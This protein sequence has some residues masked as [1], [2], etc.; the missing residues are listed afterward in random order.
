LARRHNIDGMPARR[1]IPAFSLVEIMVVVAIIGVMTGLAVATLRDVVLSGRE[2]GGAQSIANALR[3]ARGLAV[4]TH[5]RVKVVT[6]GNG[7]QTLSCASKFGAVGCVGS[8][9]FVALPQGST[10][11]SDADLVGVTLAGPGDLVFAPSGF[12]ESA[13]PFTWVVDHAQRPGDKR[14]V[15]TAGGEIRVQ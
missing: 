4:S 2:A 15:V 12:P 14:V 13:G 8:T 6:S 5:S 11:L 9:D 7:I 1:R 3:R 10:T